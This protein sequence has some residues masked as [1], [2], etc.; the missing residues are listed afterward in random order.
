MRMKACLVIVLICIFLSESIVQAQEEITVGVKKGDW[1]EYQV[2]TTGNSPEIFKVTWARI[3]ITWV[4]G[5]RIGANIT[6]QMING[7]VANLTT[8]FDLEKGKIG[9]WFII[10]SNLKPGDHFYDELMGRNIT[11]Q[12][13]EM[14]T[15]AGAQRAITNATTSERTKRWDK[16]TGLFV[17][18]E[19]VLENFSITAKATKTNMWKIQEKTSW[20]LTAFFPTLMVVSATIIGVALL[21]GF[22]KRKALKH[23]K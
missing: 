6:T 16:S 17:L 20:N 10:P 23:F 8:I 2:S 22:N 18:C 3:E 1:I 5:S 11:I 12:G 13:G 9:A 4:D 14:L 7:T 15:Y 21:V 19:D